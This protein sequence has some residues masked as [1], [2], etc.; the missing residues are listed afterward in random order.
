MSR[1]LNGSEL[2]Y[3]PIEKTCLALMFA[4]KKLRHYPQAHSIQL[5][6][7][8]DLI[9]YIM[10]KPILLG[11]LEKWALLLQEIEIVYVPQKAIKG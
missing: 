3:T 2:N 8:A 9:K 10:S 5:I 11:R 4:I 1:T 7:R 6:S